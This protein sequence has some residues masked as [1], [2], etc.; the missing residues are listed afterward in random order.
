MVCS[1][2]VPSR[3]FPRQD[4]DP[5]GFAMPVLFGGA[6]DCPMPR[7]VGAEA[8]FDRPDASRFDVRKQT[9]KV[10]DGEILTLV[11]IEDEDMLGEDEW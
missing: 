10:I 4:L 1:P 6:Q 11:L 7:K 9:C 3:W 8:C 5:A 2:Q